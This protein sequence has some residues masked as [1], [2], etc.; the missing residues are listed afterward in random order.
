[1]EDEE[2]I[3][4]P[5][6]PAG[7]AVPVNNSVKLPAF[8]PANIAPWFASVEGI[9]ELRNI[10]SQRARYFNVLA[11]LPE[12]TVV[13][14][15][16]L[17]ETNPL[18]ADPF[19]RLKARLVTA[20]QLKDI[21]RVEKLL[22]LPAMGQQ[23]P[24]ELLA[25]MIRICPRGEENSVFIN[26]LFLHKLPRE[27]RVLLSEADMA[28]KRLLSRTRFGPTTR[29]FITTPSPLSPPTRMGQMEPWQQCR[30]PGAVMAVAEALA[31]AEEVSNDGGS[32]A[33]APAAVAASPERLALRLRRP[34]PCCWLSILLGFATAI[35][36]M[37]MLLSSAT[38]QAPASGRE[39]ELP[40][41]A[42]CR[43]RRVAHP[44]HGRVF[45]QSFFGGHWS[46]L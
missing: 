24:S 32:G 35:G 11:A 22:S 16:D 7:P 34:H 26:C 27:L 20:H 39:T 30:P 25:E 19:D 1:M 42:S 18:P 10:T 43:R 15:A 6:A 14:V 37:E 12:A 28:D 9:F 23:K 38:T 46:Q 2:Q 8:W 44:H 13:L 4:L 29:S 21:Q 36:S 31:A 17:I 41:A 5:A 45:R 33:V 3:Q 40:R